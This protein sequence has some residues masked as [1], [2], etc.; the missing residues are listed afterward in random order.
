MT[1]DKACSPSDDEAQAAQ[2]APKTRT[3]KP[4][5]GR[6]V[7]FHPLESDISASSKGQPFP[8]VITHVWGNECVNL[9]VFSDGSF[10][11]LSTKLPTSVM[12]GNNPGQWS[13]PAR[14]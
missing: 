10:D 5:V 9:H 4:S 3:Q 1:T 14:V 2:D 6:I 11:A 12:H 8:A 7:D 13:W